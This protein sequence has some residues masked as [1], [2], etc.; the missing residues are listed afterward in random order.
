M[1]K[2]ISSFSL[3]FS[4]GIAKITFLV[5]KFTFIGI[6]LFFLIGI[7]FLLL[8]AS[9]LKFRLLENLVEF[10]IYRPFGVK[11]TF[12]DWQ[13]IKKKLES[14]KA[15]DFKLA[16]LEADNF[17]D[18]ILKKIGYEGEGLRERLNKLDPEIIP[19][20]EEVLKAHK[21]RNSIVFDPDYNLSL[22]EARNVIR[23][24]EQ[25]LRDLEVF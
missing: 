2:I 8:R 23:I 10:L 5:I 20:L 9:W 3:I 24:Y 15:A 13:K 21:V 7:I 12:K 22:E 18:E 4:S 6:S 17:L 16:I 25:A 1:N 14:D 11:K 19:N